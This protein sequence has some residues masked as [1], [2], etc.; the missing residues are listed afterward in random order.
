MT[1]QVRLLVFSP[2]SCSRGARAFDPSAFVPVNGSLC[3][4]DGSVWVHVRAKKFKR[5]RPNWTAPKQIQESEEFE[6]ENIVK[7]RPLLLSDSTEPIPG[8]LE[9]PGSIPGQ[10]SG[11]DRDYKQHSRVNFVSIKYWVY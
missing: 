5:A 10:P 7:C 8:M 11:T 4:R 9:V 6:Q 1:S 3:G 2:C